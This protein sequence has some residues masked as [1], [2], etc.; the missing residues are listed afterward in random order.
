VRRRAVRVC[1][2]VCVCVLMYVHDTQQPGCLDAS[3]T[4]TSAHYCR[5][6]TL[7]HTRT[8]ARRARSGAALLQLLCGYAE[9]FGA[10]LQGHSEELPLSELMGGARIRH[11]FQVWLLAWRA[12]AR[13]R[14]CVCVCVKGGGVGWEAAAVCDVGTAPACVVCCWSSEPPH[15][16][17]SCYPAHTRRNLRTNQAHTSTHTHTRASHTGGVWA[18]AALAGPLQGADG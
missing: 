9:R 5:T 8:H 4:L 17:L 10:L 3:A 14:V 12:R 11:I 13:A 7:P 18:P 2:G 1:A 16:S 15:M 6:A